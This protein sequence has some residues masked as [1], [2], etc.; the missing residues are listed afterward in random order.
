MSA[1]TPYRIEGSYYEACNCEAICPCRQ[2]NGVADGLSTYGICDFILSWK[3][4]RGHLGN[5][6]LSGLSV[7]MVGSYDDDEEGQPWRVIIYVDENA[8]DNQFQ[9]LSQIFQGKSHGNIAFTA[10]IA[11]VLDVKRA[12]ISLGHEAGRET[13]K[14]GQAAN[15]TVDRM[16]DFDGTVS[17]GIPGHDHPGQESVSSL[18]LKD[19]PFHWDYKERC[20]F[21]TDF[22]YWE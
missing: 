20:G 11:T 9:A 18:T 4:D 17:C 1:P 8:D 2:Q 3:I 7:C 19:G 15:V 21:A 12:R 14:V 16:V 22:A 13:I 10:N 6:D 5:L